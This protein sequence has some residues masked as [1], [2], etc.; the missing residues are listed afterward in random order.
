MKKG[1]KGQALV[2]YTLALVSMFGVIGLA[3]DLGWANFRR[4][5]AQKAADAAALASATAALTTSGGGFTCG[6]NQVVCQTATACPSP[7]PASASTNADTAC[8]YA[9]ANGFQAGGRQNVL[10]EANASPTT[11]PTI[12][13]V[14]PAYWVTVRAAESI[15]Q[16]F[17]AV[18][19]NR[20]ALAAARATAGVV[21]NTLACIYALDP[22]AQDAVQDQ[23]G[24][25]LTVNC[26]I[27][28][29]SGS[30]QGL[31]CDGPITSTNIYVVGGF[32]GTGCSPA[33]Q[34]GANPVGD[35]LSYL[36]PPAVPA[37][38]NYSNLQ[39]GQGQTLTLNPGTYCGG[40]TIGQGA[41]VTF[42]PGIYYLK[43]GGIDTIQS[44]VLNGTGVSF[45]Q[46][47]SGG[48]GTPLGM[49]LESQSDVTLKAPVS[50]PMTG[51][52]WYSKGNGRVLNDIQS[53]TTARLEGVLYTPG[54]DW[55]VQGQSQASQ[56]DPNTAAYTGLV[57][58]T[59]RVN[60]SGASF[61]FRS[62]Y[63]GL[64]GG[65]PFRKVALLE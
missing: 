59:L 42:N 17:S 55:L 14:T 58:Q 38:C 6:S 28:V 1:E 34:T 15:P 47:S 39:V 7:L 21:P 65:S 13:G 44:T 32:T 30:A 62:N 63:S 9:N 2:L 11:P 8:L 51:V 22:T 56:S 25:A 46:T 18:M 52:L 54:E 43:G 45:V 29:D 24:S 35:P 37:G 23:Q 41:H 31:T 61:T 27:Y 5:A 64:T 40:M 49:L 16:M 20:W 3:T 53:Q 4:Q 33:P 50:G 10:V 12:T 48:S 26:G 60:G 57:A 19:G 36:S